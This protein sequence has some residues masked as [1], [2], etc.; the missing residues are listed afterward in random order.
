[1][2]EVRPGTITKI[3]AQKRNPSRVSVFVDEK[4][5]FGAHVEIVMRFGL[6]KGQHLDAVTWQKVVSADAARMARERAID[7]LSRRA[8]S[9]AEL[10][11]YLRR[12]DFEETVVEDVVAALEEEGLLDD[13]AYAH[14]FA[15]ERFRLK[16]HGPGRI[17]SDL[18]QRGVARRWIDEATEAIQE[19][20]DL[21]AAAR[22]HAKKRWPRLR[23]SE[24]DPRRRRK[25]MYDYLR[26]RG[27]SYEVIREVVE[28]VE[29]EH[30]ENT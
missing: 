6:E 27:F 16:G 1:M 15:D 24:S 3:E 5:A 7:Y 19:E 22:E 23:R 17:R 25:K 12:K 28:G 2:E 20:R 18:M 14:A 26:R 29:T 8:R 11:R 30:E 21:R 4:F 10:R 9:V 13:R